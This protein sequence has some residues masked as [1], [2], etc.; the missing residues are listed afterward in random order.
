M[1]DDSAL[2]YLGVNGH[3]YCSKACATA[4]GQPHA[5]PIDQESYAELA[6]DLRLGGELLCPVCG[7]P[8]PV[9]W[10]EREPG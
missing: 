6:E 3:L 10:P 5:V 1:N 4:G 8:F 9:I 7:A 2:G